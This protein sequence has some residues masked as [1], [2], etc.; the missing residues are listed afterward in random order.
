MKK[1]T[2]AGVLLGAAMLFPCIAGAQVLEALPDA[3]GKA[4]GPVSGKVVMERAAHLGATMSGAAGLITMPTPDYQKE[5]TIAASFKTSNSE[6]DLY[7]N[8]ARVEVSKD[9]YIASLRYNA[10]PN[11]EVSLNNLRY[12]RSSTPALTGLDVERDHLAVG[13]KYTAKHDKN[14]FCVGFNFAPMSAKDLNLADIEQIENMR[15]VYF[16]MAE[17]IADKFTG[18]F[19]VSS[20]FTKNQEIDF[21]NGVK[22]KINRKDI[23]IGGLGLEYQVAE[24]ATIFGEAKFGNYR[25]FDYFREDS[26]R[27]RIHAGARVGVENVQLEL[28]GL[29]VTEDNPTF[30]LGGSIGF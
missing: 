19:N 7:I 26:V 5:G 9:E 30:V 28:M 12:E 8:N 6:S 22:Q 10:R 18:Y 16:T 13:L 3:R 1:I 15:N 29:N 24:A 17:N 20:V 27:H 21:G 14:D 4:A 23:L 2:R 11:L 25:D